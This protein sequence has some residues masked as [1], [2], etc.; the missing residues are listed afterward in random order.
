MNAVKG[1]SQDVYSGSCGE[2]VVVGGKEIKCTLTKIT[3]L[4]IRCSCVALKDD[5]M[6]RLAVRVQWVDDIGW[7]GPNDQIVTDTSFL[8][9]TERER[10][11]EK[12]MHYSAACNTW[13][14]AQC[15]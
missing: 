9:K 4:F 2:W 8:N 12:E 1:F 3:K 6:H 15:T 7:D 10:E 14:C 5:M 11:R 13:V